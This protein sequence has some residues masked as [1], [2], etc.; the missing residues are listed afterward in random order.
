MICTVHN[1]CFY[2]CGYQGSCNLSVSLCLLFTELANKAQEEQEEV[3]S[4]VNSDI[5]S[6]ISP[7]HSVSDG[8]TSN[9]SQKSNGSPPDQTHN[10]KFSSHKSAD[11]LTWNGTNIIETYRNIS[12]S[13][14]L[15][16][17]TCCCGNHCRGGA[18]GGERG[19]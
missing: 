3:A 2:R 4:N 10:D 17:L 9:Q 19:G 7:S 18:K 14:T 11:H 13:L 6:H 15:N 8:H 5:Q 12:K 16:R 1:I